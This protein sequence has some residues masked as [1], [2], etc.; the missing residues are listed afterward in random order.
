[1][2]D[3]ATYEV[4]SGFSKNLFISIY[5]FSN[6]EIKGWT[7]HSKCP[8]LCRALSAPQEQAQL[9]SGSSVPTGV[10]KAILAGSP[11]VGK[12]LRVINL[13]PYDAWLERVCLKWHI[14][15]PGRDVRCLSLTTNM[16]AMEYSQKIC[17]MLALEDP[18]RFSNVCLLCFEKL[19]FS[20]ESVNYSENT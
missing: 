5:Q 19:R 13:S 3:G 15:N 10:L 11:E 12:A 8:F 1:M 6:L 18:L 14:E 9:L 16:Q 17:A 7:S 20:P 4:Q 2:S